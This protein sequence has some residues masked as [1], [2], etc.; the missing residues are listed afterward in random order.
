MQGTG[1]SSLINGDFYKWDDFRLAINVNFF[2]RVFRIY[3]CDAFTREFYDYMGAP[4][5]SP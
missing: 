2:E 5:G 4:V 1:S 3:D